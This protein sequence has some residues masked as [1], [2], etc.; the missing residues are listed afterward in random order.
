MTMTKGMTGPLVH[1][2]R[3]PDPP[4]RTLGT[5]SRT[6]CCRRT[7][8]GSM[9][10]ELQFDNFTMELSDRQSVLKDTLMCVEHNLENRGHILPG[11]RW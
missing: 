1:R 2:G 8:A 10:G 6:L 7:S 5:I 4:G 9:Q 11:G 3:P